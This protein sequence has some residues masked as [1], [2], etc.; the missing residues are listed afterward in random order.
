MYFA[1]ATLAVNST[2]IAVRFVIISLF[3]AALETKEQ[4]I[5]ATSPAVAYLTTVSREPRI[6]YNTFRY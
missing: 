3:S 2:S 5:V 4:K 6:M 1:F